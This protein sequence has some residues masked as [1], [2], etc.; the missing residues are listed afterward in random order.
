MGKK[1]K[2]AITDAANEV[3]QTQTRTPSNEWC[4]EECR[5]YIKKKNEVRSKRLQQKTRASQELYKKRGIEANV[6]I[7]QKKKAWMD[8][9]ILQIEYNK[10]K[11]K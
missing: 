2:E 5:Q 10:K 1:K 8:N 11:R 4:D 3:I 9:K 6:L 7:K